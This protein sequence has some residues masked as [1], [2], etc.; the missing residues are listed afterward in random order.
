MATGSVVV[1]GLPST[2][3]WTLTPSLG[4]VA[5]TAI[6]GTGTSFTVT[7]LLTGTYTFT[8]NNGSCTSSVSANVIIA[9]Q[10]STPTA[11]VISTIFGASCTSIT[12]SIELT[13]LPSG[14][15]TLTP[16]LGAV[17]QAT[18]SGSGT[19]TT[20]ANLTLGSYTFIVSNGTCTSPISAPAVVSDNSTT[21][22]NGT[23][24]SNLV[25]DESKI[26][27]ISG[28]Y[29]MST[30]AD[31]DACS[32][33]I[34]SPAKITVAA[35]KFLTIQNH[36]TVNSGATLDVL[37]QGS[38]VML[39]DSG[40]VTNNGTT[41]IRKVTT[42]YEKFDYTYWSAPT[43]T[44]I[45]GALSA[46]RQDYSFEFRTANFSD[47][48]NDTFDDN[49]DAW[50]R[51]SQAT[52]MSAGKGYAIMAPTTG[53]F[54]TTREVVF[55]GKVNNGV[56]T[57]NVSLSA[58]NDSDIDD[59]NL[60]GNPYP[61]A[62]S[63]DR[64]L[65]ANPS[66]QGTIY[67]WTHVGN[68]SLLNPGPDVLNFKTDDYAMYNFSGGVAVAGGNS[69]ASSKPSGY[70]ASGQG[71]FAGVYDTTPIVFN[72][73]MRGKSFNNANF[74]R[75]EET[76]ALEKDRIWLNLQN[77][78]GM[79][80][81]QLIGY[82][83]NATL[84]FDK[85]YD[86]IVSKTSNYV[87]FYSFIDQAIYRIQGRPAFNENDT[88]PLGYSSAVADTFTIAID[89]KEGKLNNRSTN[90]Y[91]ED[92]LLNVTHDLKQGPYSFTTA[93]GT[94]NDRFVLRYL[95]PT[96]GTNDLEALVNEVK[97]AVN[98]NQ[99][100]ISSPKETMKEVRVYDV[101]GKLI[102]ERKNVNS[103]ELTIP[104][105]AISQQTLLINITLT[106]GQKVTRKMV[107]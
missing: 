28:N 21:T 72:N 18:I 48:N 64:F 54:P 44:T 3:T 37:N 12:G 79:F 4:G 7:S 43:A 35:N 88:V 60:L 23:A 70:I 86:G 69:A 27:I 83:D 25:P 38:L 11:P 57:Q 103:N 95:S 31:I 16:Y 96:L 107:F 97:V 40:V 6:T 71:F 98:N 15:W 24:W 42:P 53:T 66:L 39:S 73:S 30:L 89:T 104:T 106:N 102:I 2:G 101:L 84:G 26:A 20:V 59:N 87:S 61:S 58:N 32:V 33:I 1:S 77:K 68:I 67:L 22:W 41:T 76:A 17:A 52:L 19:S 36:L 34:N 74:Y 47:L 65:D 49:Q 45:G 94:F 93:K 51:V 13:G 105:R 78:D 91:L 75:A 92:K 55:S 85:G 99:I 10:P 63:A 46:W 5:Q 62:I 9:T 100:Q 90:I 14:A 82:F 81:Q 50:V 80:S 8:V 56:I 29:D